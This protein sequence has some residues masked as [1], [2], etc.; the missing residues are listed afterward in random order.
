MSIEGGISTGWYG[1]PGAKGRGSTKV[2]VVIEGK[3]ACGCRV[4]S[5]QEYQPCARGAI[6]SMVECLR[7]KQIAMHMLADSM[8]GGMREGRT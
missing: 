3:P 2:H 7:C 5:K 6:V 1:I 4:G 8:A